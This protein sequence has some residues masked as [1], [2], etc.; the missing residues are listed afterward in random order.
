MLQSLDQLKRGDVLLYSI[1]FRDNIY[2]NNLVALAINYFQNG[3]KYYHCSV[4]DGSQ[5]IESV[6]DKGVSKSVPSKD[7][8]QFIDV[9]RFSS[10]VKEISDAIKFMESKIGSKYD[11]LSYPETW[12][13]SVFAR[14]YGKKN[15]A[16]HKP[17]TN[18]PKTWFCSELVAAAIFFATGKAPRPGTHPNNTTPDDLRKGWLKKI[19]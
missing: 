16:A 10:D 14:I 7:N 19:I 8:L 13:R 2:N 15:Y 17:I 11:Y 18:D 1:E 4:W 12:V 5:Q 9:F 6:L 3:G